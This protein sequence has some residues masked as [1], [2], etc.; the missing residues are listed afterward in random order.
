MKANR[1]TARYI[2]YDLRPSKQTERRILIDILKLGADCGLPIRDYRYVGMGANRFYDF[3]MVH[4]DLGISRMVSLEHDAQMFKRAEYN[5]PFKFIK[6]QNQSAN[7][8]LTNEHH[9][10]PEVLWLDYDGALNRDV[11]T[12]IAAIGDRACRGDFAFVTVYG[13][14]PK[15]AVNLTPKDR[16]LGLEERFGDLANVVE[17]KELDDAG[18]DL[19]TLKLIHAAFTNAFAQRT[20]GKFQKLLS[21][22][23]SDSVRMVT[24]GGAFLPKGTATDYV[25]KLR[26]AMPFLKISSNQP[27][28]V[29]SF[30]YT[31]K[32]RS[33]LD[34][35]ATAST[36][37]RSS[38][39]ALLASFGITEK[40]IDAYGEVIRYIPRYIES[41][42]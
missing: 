3:I 11:V 6:V 19:A 10:N 42:I 28:L 9:D 4:R 5:C 24:Y 17:L 15:W 12:D 26:T 39:R 22:S 29:P 23:Y 18:F 21:A 34:R 14:A 20:E 1:S 25:A 30:P 27:Y 7:L 2:S 31:D 32:E 41:A 8:F 16:K 35:A 36:R 40:D 37:R 33:L 38:E 13:A